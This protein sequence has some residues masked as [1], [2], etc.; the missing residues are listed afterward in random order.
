MEIT[1]DLPTFSA[2]LWALLVY[3]VFL[4]LTFR[5]IFGPSHDQH[6]GWQ[7]DE[8]KNHL[9]V[10]EENTKASGDLGNNINKRFGRLEGYIFNLHSMV[11]DKGEQIIRFHDNFIKNQL[12]DL[13]KTMFDLYVKEHSVNDVHSSNYLWAYAPSETMFSDWTII[14]IGDHGETPYF[15]HRY[16]LGA[17]SEYFR[18]VFQPLVTLP[19]PLTT[20]ISLCQLLVDIFPSFLNYLYTG[21]IQVEVWNAVPLYWMADYFGVSY[22][23]KDVKDKISPIR[24]AE[25]CLAYINHAFVLD[26]ME[27]IDSEVEK[28]CYRNPLSAPLIRSVLHNK[29]AEPETEE[30]NRRIFSPG[31]ESIDTVL[32]ESIGT[33]PRESIDT[34][35]REPTGVEFLD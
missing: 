4:L 21:V 6:R 28:F 34:V 23:K 13:V 14:I 3:N 31:V 29:R 5:F 15:V 35:P 30:N 8:S 9:K 19:K 27:L 25:S 12:G 17:R 32:R 1:L 7:F 16:I 20:T 24:D 11:F 10:L 2:E 22:L 26:C 33:I 18:K